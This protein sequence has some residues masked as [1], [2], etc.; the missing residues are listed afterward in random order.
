ME[1]YIL[2]NGL[3]GKIWKFYNPE[4]V[5][6]GPHQDTD[7][8]IKSQM[9]W[10]H[11]CVEMRQ[12]LT[13]L[14]IEIKTRKAEI[15]YFEEGYIKNFATPELKQSLVARKMTPWNE[16][17]V[18]ESNPKPKTFVE[19]SRLSLGDGQ[20]MTNYMTVLDVSPKEIFTKLSKVEY[21]SGLV[22]KISDKFITYSGDE[23]EIHQKYDKIVSTL[24]A[25]VFWKLYGKALDF[26]SLP[27]TF[28]TTKTRPINYEGTYE[29]CYYDVTQAYT[30]IS[31]LNGLYCVEFTGELGLVEAR[32]YVDDIEDI[33]TVPGGRIISEMNLPPDN[34]IFS[35][36]FAQWSHGVVTENVIAQAQQ[37]AKET[38]LKKE[39]ATQQKIDA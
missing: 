23:A 12:L 24:P 6:V 17:P 26:K 16:K 27:I 34:I 19:A 21:S 28:V 22:S 2:G 1:S 32:K 7:P 10:L 38:R 18:V 13:D 29:M 8:F 36:R 25:P 14:N 33:W 4:M 15:G 3:S 9:I 39:N 30:R 11:D 35:G 20:E 31:C 5:L 37:Y